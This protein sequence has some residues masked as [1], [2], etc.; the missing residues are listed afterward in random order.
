MLSAGEC[1]RLLR[2]HRGGQIQVSIGGISARCVDT[3]SNCGFAYGENSTYKLV[4]MT[5]LNGSFVDGVN[6][7]VFITPPLPD[8]TQVV[9]ISRSQA[10]NLR[11]RGLSLNHISLSFS[12]LVK[13]L[14]FPVRLTS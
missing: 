10:S 1:L 8:A 14:T 9:L 4:H 12:N 6:V 7:R 5:P 13:T 11:K 3:S 2:V